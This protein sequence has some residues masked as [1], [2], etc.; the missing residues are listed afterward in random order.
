MR[1]AA[2]MHGNKTSRHLKARTAGSVRNLLLSAALLLLVLAVGAQSGGSGYDQA[3]LPIQPEALQDA[4]LDA[5]HDPVKLYSLVRRADRQN[6]SDL[7]YNTLNEMRHKQPRN[8]NVVAA[9]CFSFQVAAGEYDNPGR[10]NHPFTEAEHEGY[11]DAL[12]RAYQL[13]PKLWLTY[14]VE[15]H[16]LM[17][18]PY[19]DRKAL[20]LLRTAVK[21]AP[22]VSYTHILLAEAYSVYGTP[23]HSFQS[24]AKECN[25][26]RRLKPVSANNADILFDIYD[27]RTP[28]KN[29][30]ADA[31]R[32]LLSTVPP[33][34]HLKPSFLERLAR[35]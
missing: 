2:I 1:I 35:Y 22:D 6:L 15:G 11:N 29:K 18:S 4:L 27:I 25:V 5:S 8:A 23:Y 7:A 33:S 31:K 28:D 14:A 24:T 10:K 13:D 21:L 34:F 32:Y 12:N 17:S 26:A 9:Y 16:T 19:E 20:R 3:L 30:A